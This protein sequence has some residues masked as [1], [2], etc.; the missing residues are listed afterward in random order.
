MD[1]MGF[2]MWYQ[3]YPAR[4]DK[5]G[6]SSPVKDFFGA[7]LM[8]AYW[9][10]ECTGLDFQVDE[11]QKYLSSLQKEPKKVSS[12]SEKTYRYMMEWIQK[13]RSISPGAGGSGATRMVSCPNPLMLTFMGR[14][15]W[16]QWEAAEI[17]CPQGKGGADLGRPRHFK[18][19]PVQLEAS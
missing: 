9:M 13:T 18:R 5:Y 7:V 3:R 17:L 8:A 11:M 16:T 10:G 1:D 6:F 2:R 19:D 14:S 12:Q 15:R 4:F